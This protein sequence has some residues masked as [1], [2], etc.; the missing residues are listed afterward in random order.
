[1]PP[2][3]TPRP[4]PY[5][6][7][8]RSRLRPPLLVDRA[9]GEPAAGCRRRQPPVPDAPRLEPALVAA[10]RGEHP[11]APPPRVQAHLG[12]AVGA[13]PV[14]IQMQADRGHARLTGRGED[15][16]ALRRRV[17]GG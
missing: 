10:V 5:T 16:V 12:L 17:A 11:V 1:V 8:F 6:T 13:P 3:P 14:Q 9:G 2:P 4:F 15:A 7:L